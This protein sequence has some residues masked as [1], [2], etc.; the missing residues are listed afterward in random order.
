ML[1]IM[2]RVLVIAM[3]CMGT[4]TYGQQGSYIEVVAVD[5]IYL[6]PVAYEY[7]ITFG[8]GKDFMGIRIDDENSDMRID[9]PIDEVEDKLKKGNFFYTK[10]MDHSSYSAD[11]E[12][13]PTIIVHLKNGS[14]LEFM[15]EILGDKNFTAGK[16]EEIKYESIDQ[17]HMRSY[18][19]MY[20]SAMTQASMLATIAGRS[21]GPLVHAAESQ[22]MYDGWSGMYSEMMKN[23][24]FDMFGTQG[25]KDQKVER[26][27]AFRFEL[28]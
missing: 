4:V 27:F 7:K 25:I 13:Y 19:Q 2:N 14:E 18:Q 1:N 28:K 3:S 17:Y 5:T 26:K 21:L 15:S 10:F 22:G 9:P 8:A 23:M 6:K 24:P 16:V 20:A 11:V 12:K